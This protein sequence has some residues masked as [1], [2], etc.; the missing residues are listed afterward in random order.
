MDSRHL[1]L[2]SL[3]AKE[4][5]VLEIDTE[6]YPH[7]NTSLDVNF[8]AFVPLLFFSSSVTRTILTI[9]CLFC[10]GSTSHLG[11]F[12]HN[13][14]QRVSEKSHFTRLVATSI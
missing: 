4:S 11:I 8:S 12:A 13:V 1:T 14:K 2:P 10:R 7:M 3:P 6:I 5:F 9:L